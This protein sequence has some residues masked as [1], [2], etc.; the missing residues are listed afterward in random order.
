M[1]KLLSLTF[2]ASLSALIFFS[3]CEDDGGSGTPDA[4]S[5]ASPSSVIDITTEGTTQV[6]FTIISAGGYASSTITASAGTAT[7]NS[8]PA[9]GAASGTVVVDFTAPASDVVALVSIK[10]TD[11]NGKTANG[12]ATV[13]VSAEVAP[14]VDVFPSLDGTGTVTWTSDNVYILRG[15]IFVND[16]Q[17]LTI[18]AG[19]VIKGQP[20]QGAGASALIVARGGKIEANGESDNPIIFTGL[21]DNLDG[22]IPETEN[23]LWGGIIVLGNSVT[24][25]LTLSEGDVA[26]GK[27]IE[28]IPTDEKRGKYGKGTVKFNDVP[29]TYDEDEDDDSGII[30]YVSI[31]H[32]GSVIGADNE[33]NGLSLGAVGKGTDIEGVE[34]F[35]N[36]D[37]GIE[38][39]GGT[40]DIR[41][42]V[43]AYVGDDG[44]DFDEGFSGTVQYGIVYH[45]GKTVKSEDPRGGEWDGGVDD[46]EEVMPYATVKVANV[47]FVYDNDKND[48]IQKEALLIRDNSAASV[49][50]SIF[51]GH[52]DQ[53]SVE[54]RNDK[55]NSYD[56]YVEGLVNIKGNIVY[57]VNGETSDIKNSFRIKY[58]KGDVSDLPGGQ[59][60]EDDFLQDMADNNTLVDPGFGTGADTFKPS[61]AEVKTD[62]ATVP[63]GLDQSTYKG[64]IDPDAADPFFKGWTKLYGWL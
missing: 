60:D 25:N 29:F 46:N 49:Y 55:A 51:S 13:N 26:E 59:T 24:N 63:T 23:A 38:C 8:E 44:L 4:P 21:A 15:F 62:I 41:K 17:T 48:A 10:V 40:V 14:T 2:L 20:G 47:T 39:F 31:R 3:S 11:K 54:F 56:R 18:E 5:V 45:T 53:I 27:S 35:A 52:L 6:T 37:D 34:V 43:L 57:N 28:G 32:G 19:T 12:Q 1:K 33:I 36:L 50:N 7:I 9:D 64:G 58:E 16:G 61:A 22:S 30:H 42:V